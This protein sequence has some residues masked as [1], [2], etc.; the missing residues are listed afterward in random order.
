MKI[1][2]IPGKIKKEQV[3]S[4]RFHYD[5]RIIDIVKTMPG[6][7]WSPEQGFWY[8][9]KSRFNLK[10]FTESFSPD[11]EVDYS[12]LEIFPGPNLQVKKF[13]GNRISNTPPEE[14]NDKDLS[15]EYLEMLIRKRYSPNTIKTYTSYMKAF[16]KE[17][18][19]RNLDTIT[20]REIN[21]YILSLIRNKKISASQQ[22]Q[23]ISAIKFYYEKVLG[24]NRMY[25]QI[26]R[27][28]K[29]KKLPRVLTVEE[30]EQILKHCNNPKHKCILMTLYSGGLRRSELI[31]L[32][33]NDIDTDQMLI[34]IR[35]SKGNKDRYTLLSETL[36]KLLNDYFRFYKPMYWVFEGQNGGQYS[37]TSI[38]NIMRKAL[39]NAR[40][41]KHATPHTLRHSFATHLLEQGINLRYIQELLGHSSTKTTEIYTHV[42]SRQ[43]SKI[44]NP[45]DNLNPE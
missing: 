34:R 10:K 30:V 32:K 29:Q 15:P 4:I 6:R 39:R 8:I 27:P 11:I 3:I 36:L 24:R 35:D 2:L 26:S 18:S 16:R 13:Q 42:S 17:F 12:A 33:I 5:L 38:E 37:A 25:F 44:K 19:D 20:T 9:P 43:L 7:K 23:R 21:A 40:I 45:L 41:T 22:N 31:N 14:K 28:K 1:T